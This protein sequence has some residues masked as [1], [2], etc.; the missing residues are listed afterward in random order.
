MRGTHV[1]YLEDGQARYKSVTWLLDIIITGKQ[2]PLR[3][4]MQ[5]TGIVGIMFKSLAMAMCACMENDEQGK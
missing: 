2:R 5:R 4:F 3:N 1:K